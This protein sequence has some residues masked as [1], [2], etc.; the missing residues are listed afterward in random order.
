MV[1][2]SVRQGATVGADKGYDQA[3]FTTYPQGTQGIKAHVARKA[4]GSSVDG[5]TAR[6]KGACGGAR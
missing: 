6:G 4:T 3:E 2:C 5:R 1:A